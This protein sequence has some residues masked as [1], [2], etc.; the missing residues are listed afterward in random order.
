[1]LAVNFIDFIDKENLTILYNNGSPGRSSPGDSH[2]TSAAKLDA[3]SIYRVT[4]ARHARVRI[5][6]IYPDS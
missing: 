3:P 5:N 6:W 1:M 4:R 2:P